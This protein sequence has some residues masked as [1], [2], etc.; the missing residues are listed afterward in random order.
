MSKMNN[1]LYIYTDETKL[2]IVN[3]REELT[4]INS[5]GKDYLRKQNCTYIHMRIIVILSQAK[6]IQ[7]LQCTITIDF[8]NM[9]K[10]KQPV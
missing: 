8:M 3:R 7:R 2:S 5:V 9:N 1:S 6:K 10:L 4:L